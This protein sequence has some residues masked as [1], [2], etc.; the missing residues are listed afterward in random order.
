MHCKLDKS[1]ESDLR[2]LA[3]AA[4]GTFLRQAQ[5]VFESFEG[6]AATRC[7]RTHAVC[8]A[9][10]NVLLRQL[11]VHRKAHGLH[12]ETASVQSPEILLELACDAIE[13]FT[14]MLKSVDLKHDYVVQFAR[15]EQKRKPK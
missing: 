9:S 2:H 6:Q 4:Y 11:L 8:V 14:G 5:E 12:P 15:I 3:D 10:V 7:V 13:I 1:D